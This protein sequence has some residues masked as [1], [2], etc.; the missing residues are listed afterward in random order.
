MEWPCL[1]RGWSLSLTLKNSWGFIRASLPCFPPQC[2]LPSSLRE[3]THTASPC[4]Q[5]QLW[6]A[7]SSSSSCSLC[8]KRHQQ[9]PASPA[10]PPMGQ[11]RAGRGT[12]RGG[13][14]EPGSKESISGSSGEVG[15]AVPSKGSVQTRGPWEKVSVGGTQLDSHCGCLVMVFTGVCR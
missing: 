1:D 14:E 3:D 10:G 2:P 7:S 4:H 6:G 12:Q 13:A 11:Q 15:K 8:P 5:Q 9:S